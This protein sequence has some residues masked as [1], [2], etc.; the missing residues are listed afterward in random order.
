VRNESQDSLLQLLQT[1]EVAGP[2]DAGPDLDLIEPGSI[3]G[4]P[5][6][7]NGQPWASICSLGLS[8]T[9]KNHLRRAGAHL[10]AT[11]LGKLPQFGY[12]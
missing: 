2:Q 4:Q 5:A 9:H 11:V 7:L 1:P 8:V 10:R 3:L 12:Q 6:N